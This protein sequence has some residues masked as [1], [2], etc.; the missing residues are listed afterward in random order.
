M[1]F[2][3]KGT[4]QESKTSSCCSVDTNEVVETKEDSCCG[5]SESNESSC[6]S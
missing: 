6:C 4:G 3:K 1:N 5:T 2:I